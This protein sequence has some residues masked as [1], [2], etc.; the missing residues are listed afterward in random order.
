MRN[1]LCHLRND[2]RNWGAAR[3]AF[4]WAFRQVPYLEE[5]ERTNLEQGQDSAFSRFFIQHV[6]E[7][8][9]EI[10]EEQDAALAPDVVAQMRAGAE[11]MLTRPQ[12]AGTFF[13]TTLF[14]E[15]PDI[16]HLFRTADMDAL[17]RHLIDTVV[18]LSQA[19]D[20]G[21]EQRDELRNLAKIHQVNQI[22]S[23]DYD[24][25]VGPL[26]QTLSEFGHPLNERTSRGWQVLFS[27]V[28]RIVAEPMIQQERILSEA[29]TFIDQ[30]ATE[31]GWT[32]AKLHKR[33]SE[34]AREVRMTGVY[35]HTNEE[36]DHGAKLAWR[37]APK[38]IGR[39]S[40]K[41]LIVRDCRHVTDADS[42]YGECL[43]H[44]RTATNGGNIEIVLTVFVRCN[45][46]NAGAPGCGTASWS[47][48]QATRCPM[49]RYAVIAPIST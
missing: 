48:M 43:Q 44:L 10:R 3:E 5:Y 24:R 19:A 39:I 8:M 11:M 4:L 45:P 26:L 16:V 6:E 22:P 18:F 7:P 47:A 30:V 28:S 31:L 29:R 14:D 35:T 32:D 36:L 33:W 17:S 41:S 20:E 2:R 27:R 21:T 23:R 42:I 13:Y 25:L 34:I 37:N 15:C 12:D 1:L 40:W 9:N 46:A 38:C 49:V